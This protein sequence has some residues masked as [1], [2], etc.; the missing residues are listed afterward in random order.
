[1]RTIDAQEITHTIARLCMEANY[2]L[3]AD[4]LAAFDTALTRERSP[5]GRDVLALL[6]EN[7]ATARTQRIP[8]CQD[9]G[10]VIC[11]VELGQDAH[12]QGGLL[13]DAINAG[14]RQGYTIRQR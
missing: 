8:Y 10:F 4:M 9:T 1:M 2:N 5:A 3:G 11:F 6:K 7:A 13:D 14:V 12:I